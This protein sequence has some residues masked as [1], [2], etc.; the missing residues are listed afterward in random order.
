MHSRIAPVQLCMCSLKVVLFDSLKKFKVNV[1]EG[2]E[3]KV[4]R[5]EEGRKGERG[6][7]RER[8]KKRGKGER[9]GGQGKA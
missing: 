9:E 2:R 3:G 8:E 6:R 4:G 5:G 7:E 1:I